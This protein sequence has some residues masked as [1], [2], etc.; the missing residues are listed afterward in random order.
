MPNEEQSKNLN[1]FGERLWGTKYKVWYKLRPTDD[2]F[3]T[4]ILRAKDMLD[5]TKRAAAKGFVYRVELQEDVVGVSEGQVSATNPQLNIDIVKRIGDKLHVNWNAITPDTLLKGAKVELEH[6]DILPDHGRSWRD[7]VMVTRIALA[8]LKERPDY[9]MKLADM[10]RSAVMPRKN[11]EPIIKKE[12]TE[13]VER[14][15]KP[16]IRA[17]INHAL[18]LLDKDNYRTDEV[19][20]AIISLQTTVEKLRQ[21][22][23]TSKRLADALTKVIAQI[24][25]SDIQAA[26][27]I[28]KSTLRTVKRDYAGVIEKMVREEIS[29]QLGMKE[30][31]KVDTDNTL[32][33]KAELAKKRADM[34]KM[35][36]QQKTLAQSRKNTK[37]T[38]AK[39]QLSKQYADVGAKKADLGV[40]VAQMRKSLN[41]I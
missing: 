8:H 10:E 26:V 39:R 41:K 6:E 40:K 4:L 24:K 9:Y 14:I 21:G 31:A 27:S 25:G 16:F 36:Q 38:L 22:G 35:V 17:G 18:S 12:Y 37:D 5:A 15:D 23:G 13:I 28:L 30:A 20:A 34:Q 33:K 2:D 1:E 11:Q 3:Q 32:L 29:K 7:I 19:Q